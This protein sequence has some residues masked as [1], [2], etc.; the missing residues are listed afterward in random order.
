MLFPHESRLVMIVAT[1]SMCDVCGT[2]SL[3]LGGAHAAEFSRLFVAEHCRR[4]GLGKQLVDHAET[5][6]RRAG[7]GALSC[8]MH[9]KN[10]DALAFYTKLGFSVA[11][12]FVDGDLL[13]SRPVTP[14]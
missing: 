3:R 11:F 10:T 14:F 9:P 1:D 2:I 5:V 6:A 13:L 8:S 4:E 7:V 12:Q